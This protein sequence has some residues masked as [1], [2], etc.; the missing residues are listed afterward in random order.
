MRVNRK[1]EAARGRRRVHK[2]LG[3]WLERGIQ[4]N[5]RWVH[6]GDRHQTAWKYIEKRG[7]HYSWVYRSMHEGVHSLV[8]E[9]GSRYFAYWIR[10]AFVLLGSIYPSMMT[11]AYDG[12]GLG[13]LW[14]FFGGHLLIL[15][16]RYLY[17][18][19][20]KLDAIFIQ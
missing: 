1:A 17:I 3:D 5:T 4:T 7:V 16:A 9:Q 18:P 15:V 12:L 8:H 14:D 6:W 13:F 2:R 19:P 20:L 11:M 10:L